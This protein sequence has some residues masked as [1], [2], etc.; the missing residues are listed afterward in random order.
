MY[1]TK[2][3]YEHRILKSCLFCITSQTFYMSLYKCLC[4]FD[5][6]VQPGYIYKSYFCSQLYDLYIFHFTEIGDFAK[7]MTGFIPTWCG[8]VF[9]WWHTTL[10]PWKVW[11]AANAQWNAI[12]PI[13]NKQPFCGW[14]GIPY[15]WKNLL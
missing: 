13:I 8:W 9:N 6:K 14:K 2:N 12:F 7:V 3:W 1:R 10:L 4:I 5:I 11:Y 15:K